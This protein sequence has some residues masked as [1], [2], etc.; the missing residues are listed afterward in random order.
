M[1]CVHT[2]TV[3]SDK[4][5]DGPLCIILVCS[6]QPSVIL[7]SLLEVS[8]PPGAGVAEGQILYLLKLVPCTLFIYKLRISQSQNF[9]KQWQKIGGVGYHPHR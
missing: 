2:S 9:Q 7:A 3:Q 6:C 5:S 8:K 4:A 1:L